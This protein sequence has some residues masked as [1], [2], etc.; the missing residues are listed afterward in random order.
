MKEARGKRKKRLGKA[1]SFAL[2]LALAAGLVWAAPAFAEEEAEE[3]PELIV[4][5]GENGTVNGHR[6]DFTMQMTPG[7]DISLA[8]QGDQG[9]AVGQVLVNDLPLEDEDMEGIA[10]ESSASLVLEGIDSSLS[11]EVLFEPEESG[12]GNDENGEESEEGSLAEDQETG[13][14]GEEDPEGTAE[15]TDPSDA[16]GGD[17]PSDA[18]GA[19]DDDGAEDGASE[20][21]DAPDGDNGDAPAGTSPK[22]GDELPLI[23]VLIFA[24]SATLIGITCCGRFWRRAKGSGSE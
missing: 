22:T 8:L 24:T 11:V 9:F 18:E 21:E 16:G 12:E 6:E 23:A 19:E 4:F 10:G 13:D 1:G 17:A 7:E 15:V 2:A 20:D 5:V 3:A 14:T